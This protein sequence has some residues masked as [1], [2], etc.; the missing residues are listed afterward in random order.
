QLA[1]PSPIPANAGCPAGFFVAQ[2]ADGPG[3]GLTAGS[4]GMEVL[5]DEPGT[6]TLAGGLNFGGLIDSG[7]VGF[8]GFNIRNERN[9][10][11][12]VD[13]RLAG[14]PASSSSASLP[15]RVRIARRTASSS[16]T[17][18]EAAP[19]ISLAAPFVGSVEVAPGFYEVTVGPQSGTPGGAAEGQFFFEL[20]T[21][22]LD[23]AGGGFEG[24]AV[25]GGY[26]APHPFD[27]V[28]GF[29]AF[30]LATPHSASVRLLSQPSYGPA[31]ARDLRLR[32][33]DTR[34]REVLILPAD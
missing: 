19:T 11:Q 12:R 17:V 26:H 21:R 10:P 14:S 23:R 6:R 28:S 15:V 13:V 8:A 32:M 27:G 16:D 34:S 7:Q 24:G 33:L 30:C 22:F 1:L 20:T 29:A 25:V 5:L 3:A 2:A 4:F 18:F 9:E 31:G